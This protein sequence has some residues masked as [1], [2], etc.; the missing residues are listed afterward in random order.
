MKLKDT[1]LKTN[2][3]VDNK[4]EFINRKFL[5]T[6]TLVLTIGICIISYF[7]FLKIESLNSKNQ[8][9]LILLNRWVESFNESYW[10]YPDKL[11]EL[12]EKEIIK[13]LD[14]IL[15]KSN[16]DNFYYEKTET[17]FVLLTK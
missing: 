15:N 3:L 4:K 2:K 17:G 9:V 14:L 13:P 7:Q 12:D 10:S 1:D 16:I 5:I 8:G 6:I 11:Q